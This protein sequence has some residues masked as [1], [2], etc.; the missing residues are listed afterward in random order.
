M[1]SLLPHK[2]VYQMLDEKH[3]NIQILDKL[4]RS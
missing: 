4:V 3:F 1:K 2:I